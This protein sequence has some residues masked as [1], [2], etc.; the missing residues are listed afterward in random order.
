M[1]NA[2]TFLLAKDAKDEELRILEAQRLADEARAEG[3]ANQSMWGVITGT[4]AAAVG[5]TMG[6]DPRISYTIGS[7]IGENV[8]DAFDP[9]GETTLED[10]TDLDSYKFYQSNL[11]EAQNAYELQN[12]IDAKNQIMGIGQDLFSVA[13][14]GYQNMNSGLEGASFLKAGR[15]KGT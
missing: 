15:P 13:G 5:M 14:Y 1:A 11:Q 2:Q 3:E 9:R 8:T 6:I 12:E 4:V 10:V 7:Q